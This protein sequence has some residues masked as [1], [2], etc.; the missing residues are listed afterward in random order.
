[1]HS[2]LSVLI[3]GHNVLCEASFSVVHISFDINTGG[4]VATYATHWLDTIKVRMQTC[5]HLYANG[6]YCLRHT[7]RQEGVRGLYLGA[8]PAVLGQ[9][10]KT[11]VVFMC[12]G[13][14][15][16]LVRRL[17][18]HDKVEE[19]SAWQHAGAG[20]MTGITASFVLCPL[21]LLK[22]RL[23]ALQQVTSTPVGGATQ[24]ASSTS[25]AKQKTSES[26]VRYGNFQGGIF[27][28]M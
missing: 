13:L 11:A 7:L 28:A 17:T 9:T 23:Q 16:E 1:M 20:A 26:V 22:C 25:G 10:C 3:S 12:Y 14:C 24:V 19:L 21:E 5:P 2:S 27:C 18:D 15:E 4:G 8:A 6:L